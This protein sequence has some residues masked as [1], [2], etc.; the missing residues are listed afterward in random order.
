VLQPL[1][2]TASWIDTPGSG[3]AA[4]IARLAHDVAHGVDKSTLDKRARSTPIGK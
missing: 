1:A 3:L 4:T 2:F